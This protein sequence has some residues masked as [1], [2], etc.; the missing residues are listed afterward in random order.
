MWFV[1]APLNVIRVMFYLWLNYVQ[2]NM[3]GHT[4]SR[5]WFYLEPD[6]S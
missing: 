1:G 5:K 2:A 4:N 6:Y 3:A